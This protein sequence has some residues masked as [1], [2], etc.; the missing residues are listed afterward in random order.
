[1]RLHWPAFAGPSAAG[2]HTSPLSRGHRLT[3][4]TSITS[5]QA[6]SPSR[7]AKRPCKTCQPGSQTSL[8]FT[9]PP[10]HFPHRRSR[11]HII[12]PAPTLR[13]A[14][15]S[16]A[17]QPPLF[18]APADIPERPANP[19]PPQLPARGLSTA[20]HPTLIRPIRPALRPTHSP[21]PHQRSVTFLHATR[22][23]LA[24]DLA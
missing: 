1:M 3:S 7:R 9:H 13:I 22:T 14:Q 18:S 20:R 21:S 4:V 19:S 5:G 17:R 16:A 11:F 8:A 23:H 6:P 24:F 12:K 2:P 15:P 10:L